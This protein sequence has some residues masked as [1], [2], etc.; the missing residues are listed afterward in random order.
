MRLAAGLLCMMLLSCSKGSSRP[1][2]GCFAELSD[3]V[4]NDSAGLTTEMLKLT[5]T[6]GEIGTT[7]KNLVEAVTSGIGKGL[8]EGTGTVT[9]ASGWTHDSG[10]YSFSTKGDRSFT[11]R[12]RFFEETGTQITTDLFDLSN[13]LVEPTITAVSGDVISIAYQ[14][15]GV[16]AHLIGF[17]GNTPNPYVT[18]SSIF[19]KSLTDALSSIE[20]EV[21]F[22][23]AS[24]TDGRQVSISE[25]TERQTLISFV[26]KPNLDFK[27][28][29]GQGSW[30]SKGQILSLDSWNI[31]PSLAAF[32]LTGK[33]LFSVT[34]DATL[35]DFKGEIDYGSELASA[36]TVPKLNLLCPDDSLAMATESPILSE[37]GS[38]FPNSARKD[39][40]KISERYA[41]Q[42]IECDNPDDLQTCI[43]NAAKAISNGESLSLDVALVLDVSGSMFNEMDYIKEKAIDIATRLSQEKSS[44]DSRLGLVVFSDIVDPYISK[45]ES[46]LEAD[47][48]VYQARIRDVKLLGGGDFPEAHLDGVTMAIEELDWRSSADLRL[49]VLISDATF[50]NPSPGGVSLESVFEKALGRSILIAPILMGY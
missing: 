4:I 12:V 36:M 30:E 49:I 38:I 14:S 37:L 42:T 28:N 50:K 45:V 23:A 21:E 3:E 33:A 13:F 27:V 44:T 35:G 43:I 10:V 22:E 9:I 26:A 5:R 7:V 18:S 8:K 41:T 47:S 31:Q 1:S 32:G 48:A 2:G 29:G 16:L 46:P 34:G 25:A 15:R 19:T 6:Q 24:E 39:F 40:S 20:I 11:L 17:N